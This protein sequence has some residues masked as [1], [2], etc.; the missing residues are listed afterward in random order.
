MRMTGATILTLALLCQPTPD[1]EAAMA[2]AD[3]ALQP[4]DARPFVRYFT[5]YAMPRPEPDPA[6]GLMRDERPD[7]AA[8]LAF[9]ANSLSSQRVIRRPQ[10]VRGSDTLLRIDLRD[11]GWS[12]DAWTKVTARD[13]YY[14]TPNA[15]VARAD[16]FIVETSD[17]NRSTAYYELLYGLG[18]EP[19]NADQM[20]ARWR[21]DLAGARALGVETGAV[22]D[23]GDS[24]VALHNRVLSRVRSLTGAAHQSFDF[25]SSAGARDALENL[26]N[27]RPDAQE[28]I[29]SLP[30]GLH[31]YQLSGADGA[32]QEA[33]PAEIAR[34][35]SP[36]DG[37]DP[38]VR[39]P[40]SCVTCHGPASGLHPPRNALPELLAL[41]DGQLRASLLA[42]DKATQQ[43]IEGFYLTDDG[44]QMRLDQAD[45]ALAVR[46]CN[47]LEPDANADQFA[48]LLVAYESPVSAEQAARELGVAV[49]Q[50]KRA[51]AASVKGRLVGLAFGR[52]IPRDVFEASSYLELRTL[53]RIAK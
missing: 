9:W 13:P 2:V 45:Y 38:R 25:R 49:E 3:Y 53:L 23:A 11:Y 6:F 14:R 50:L 8:V 41:G 5:L 4:A 18:K 17:G 1:S 16:W 32:R 29:T 34:D 51:C 35:P 43:R 42:K 20:R 36:P 27:P 37:G 28:F 40:R 39:N 15:L 10:A 47:G 7:A 48:R 44:R 30:N 12:P 31:V 21:V 22:V 24:I 52:P 26:L 33:A 46:A 19:K